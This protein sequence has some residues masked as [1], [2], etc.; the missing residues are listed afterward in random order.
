MKLLSFAIQIQSVDG[1][2][3][4]CV[5]ENPSGLSGGGHSQIIL[6]YTVIGETVREDH[7]LIPGSYVLINSLDGHKLALAVV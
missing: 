7:A 3:G 6:V 5:A 1:V 4:L 2:G